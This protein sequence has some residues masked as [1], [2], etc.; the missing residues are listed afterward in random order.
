VVDSMEA[1]SVDLAASGNT[2]G[3]HV[4]MMFARGRIEGE[5]AIDLRVAGV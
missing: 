4:C 5:R 3:W 2:G 1:E